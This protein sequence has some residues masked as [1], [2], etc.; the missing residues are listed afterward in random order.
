MPHGDDH[1]HRHASPSEHGFALGIG[2]N[3]GYVLVEAAAG[4]WAG[5]L[6][7]LADAGHNLSDV[8]GLALAWAAARLA[9]RAPTPRRSYGWRRA[10]ILAALAN[11]MLL[12]VAVGAIGLEAIGRL[13]DPAPV[14]TGP[15]LWVAA[16]GVVV[17]GGTA[18]LFLRGRQHDLNR[19]GAFLHMVADAGVTL[20][21]I[22]TALLIGATGWA[23]LDPAVALAIAAAI[24][25]GTWSLLRESMNLAMD[26]VPRGI[27]PAEVEAWLA[28][29]P[30]V[31]SVHDLHIWAM[32][33]TETA[34]TAHL[35]C[36][37]AGPPDD[38][39]LAEAARG[40]R[41]RFGI[42]HATLQVERGDAA[43][44]CALAPREVV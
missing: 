17:N 23:W 4:L 27:D 25:A 2:L 5:S 31:A 43:H 7:L 26:A 34:L 29:L 12:L 39:F 21:V 19:R 8:L 30:G 41:A 14:A 16:A 32:S 36:P 11:A 1:G 37:A 3:L 10:S 33:T 18:L 38:A 40:L 13:R 24:L 28:A 22:A 6:T 44:P 20:G 15:M 9:R 42:G 35:V